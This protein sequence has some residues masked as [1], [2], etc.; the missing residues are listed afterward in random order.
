LPYLKYQCDDLT[1]K[2]HPLGGWRHN[3]RPPEIDY[4]LLPAIGLAGT[5]GMK[6]AIDAGVDI[7][8][9]S[10][11]RAR[12]FFHDGAGEMGVVLYTKDFKLAR[13][14]TL[15][16]IAMQDGKLDT[17]WGHTPAAAV[18]FKMTGD[19]KASHLCSFIATHGYNSVYNGHG[20]HF[21]NRFWTPLG[22]AVHGKPSYQYFMKG[23]RWFRELDRM[24]D[25]SL[26]IN[27]PGVLGAGTGLALVEPR[28]RLTITG[29]PASPF[30]ANAPGYLK[31]ALDA[32]W[33]R[34]Y[35]GC[36]A[37]VTKL[38]GA[39]MVSQKERPTVERLA[40]SARYVREGVEA[41][42]RRLAAL[43]EED[44]I[45]EA[46]RYLTQLEVVA[47][48]EDR[49]L[50]TVREGLAGEARR[51]DK[52]LYDARLRSLGPVTAAVK[53]KDEAQE[54]REWVQ[55]TTE[56][57]T[58]AS[59]KG[60][61]KVPLEEATRWRLKVLEDICQAPTG[62]NRPDFD[63]DDWDSTALPISWANNHT[64]LLRATFEVEDKSSFDKLRFA[65]WALRQQ[66]MEVYLNGA[67]VARVNHIEKKTANVGSELTDGATRHL[68]K[69]KN[70]VAIKTRH[71]WRWGMLFMRVYND[72]FAFRLEA[73][74]A[75]GA[76]KEIA[77]GN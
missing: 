75:R 71:Y 27:E 6:L 34:D 73:R 32:Y 20:G 55:L 7:D 58:P 48:R 61:H 50:E 24:Y 77:A 66:G 57:S 52:K 33:S 15:D 2:Q 21:W 30:A 62:W 49:R 41:D 18:L 11:E 31:P 39:G 47:P 40:Q 70:V 22:S 17:A 35:A 36:E 67:L 53:R 10:F 46:T 38:L 16:P 1:A 64:A 56:A 63:D 25:G 60:A 76:G 51:D 72:G 12:R 42:F 69:G 43:V 44:R 26:I 37:L 54:A 45:Y 9:E 8:K 68:K 74:K 13:P 19:V 5:M 23:H 3:L 29:A 14:V 65:A 28:H 59:K 4:C